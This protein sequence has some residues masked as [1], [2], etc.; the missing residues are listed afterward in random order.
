M[1]SEVLLRIHDNAIKKYLEKA[2]PEAIKCIIPY[3]KNAY[4]IV[5]KVDRIDGASPVLETFRSQVQQN[6]PS[7]YNFKIPQELIFKDFSTIF[8]DLYTNKQTNKQACK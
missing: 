7:L 6:L 8:L 1:Q 4:D 2:L 5:Q 3:A